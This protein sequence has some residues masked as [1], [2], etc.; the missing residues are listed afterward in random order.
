[1]KIIGEIINGTRKSV[2]TAIAEKNAGFIVS[3]ARSQVENGA[4]FL[5]FNAG[6]TPDR[7]AEDLMQNGLELFA[8][9]RRGRV[10]SWPSGVPRRLIL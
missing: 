10:G 1:M 8:Q 9:R 6:S 5:D 7:E 3:L 4:D 2:A